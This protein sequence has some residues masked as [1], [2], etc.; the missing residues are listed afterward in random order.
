MGQLVGKLVNTVERRQIEL[1]M[2][3]AKARNVQV[4]RVNLLA[5]QPVSLWDFQKTPELIE[6]GYTIA[7]EAI[8]T[9]P[10][11]HPKEA[12]GWLTWLRRR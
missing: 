6:T 5:R 8:S 11:Q 3:L 12:R 2:A 1:E 4:Q 9:W 7:K 10:H